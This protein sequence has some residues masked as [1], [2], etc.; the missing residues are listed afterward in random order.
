[1]KASQSVSGLTPWSG[2]LEKL[3][4]TQIDRKLLAVYGTQ[5]FIT[6][7]TLAHHWSLS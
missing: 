7:F 3:I 5:R 1:M 6:T 2:V 4:V